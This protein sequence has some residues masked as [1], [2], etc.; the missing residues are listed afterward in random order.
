MHTQIEPEKDRMS[1]QQAIDDSTLPT[2]TAANITLSC[3]IPN[4]L[5][6]TTYNQEEKNPVHAQNGKER[7]LC[8]GIHI[9][10]YCV[11]TA[12]RLWIRPSKQ[13]GFG[14]VQIGSNSI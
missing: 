9:A 10:I 7:E 5:H 1:I 6:S 14:R 4:R 2:L 12:H 11:A 3:L 13:V 8:R